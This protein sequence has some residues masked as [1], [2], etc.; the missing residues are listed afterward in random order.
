A[1]RGRPARAGGQETCR[2]SPTGVAPRDPAPA[3]GG[4]GPARRG[5]AVPAARPARADEGGSAAG[6]LPAGAEPQRVPLPELTEL[7][8]PRGGCHAR[9]LWPDPSRVLVGGR[10]GVHRR[11]PGRAAGR[12]LL[13]RPGGRPAPAGRLRQPAGAEEA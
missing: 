2:S 7:T 3:D 1:L 9:L 4:G 6:L 13:R 10:R 5:A 11:R 12:R 8:S